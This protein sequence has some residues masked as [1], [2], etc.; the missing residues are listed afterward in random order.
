L[1][2]NAKEK[3]L[4]L[5]VL[6]FAPVPSGEAGR[7]RWIGKKKANKKMIGQ[8]MAFWVESYMLLLSQWNLKFWA[9]VKIDFI[10]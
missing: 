7:E 8:M 1:T 9:L 6:G 4:T 3:G 10:K 5:P 2:C